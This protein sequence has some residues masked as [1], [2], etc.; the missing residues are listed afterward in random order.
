MV[1]VTYD[2]NTETPAGRRRLRRIAKTCQ[3]FGQRVQFSV[4]ECS[5]DPAQWIKFRAK[6]IHEMNPEQDS[7]RFYFLG[8]NW[9]HR[10]EHAGTKEP[11]DLE[12]VLIL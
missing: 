6:L 12:G 3:N 8:S 10:I 4:F 2:V 5:V 9:Q 7:L 1:L 11:R